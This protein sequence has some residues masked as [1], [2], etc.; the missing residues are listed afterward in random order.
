[1][2]KQ[3]PS[4]FY[5]EPLRVTPV[6]ADVRRVMY[7]STDTQGQP[8]AVTGTVMMPD[9]PWR[10]REVTRPWTT[11][12]RPLVV[13]SPGTKGNGDQCAP[14][15]RLATGEDYEGAILKGLLAA[16]YAVAIPDF[17]GVGTAPKATY[18]A[19][20]ATGNAVLDIARAAQRSGLPGL[21]ADGPVMLAGY[22][23]G[24]EASAAGA[25]LAAT[26]APELKMPGAVPA[27][28]TEVARSLDG[29]AYNAFLLSAVSGLGTAYDIDL[30]AYANAEGMAALEANDTLCTFNQIPR[31]AFVDSSRYTNSGE[32]LSTLITSD[33]LLQRVTDEQKLGRVAPTFPVLVAQSELDDVIPAA[34]TRQFARD[35]CRGGTTVQYA[36]SL[37]PTHIAGAIRFQPEMFT[38]LAARAAGLPPV[39]SC[40]LL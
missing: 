27:D 21:A 22:S 36:A 29:S 1:M 17:E 10:G 19:R 14:S 32:K 4:S 30:T 16:G 37:A 28:L 24:G 6:R 11:S 40:G 7:K 33:P 8:M 35:W 5:L 9:V 23:Q 15:R 3:E 20:V 13:F 12:E 31:F 2:I 18:M 34:Q 39:N 26:Y 25:E 38:F